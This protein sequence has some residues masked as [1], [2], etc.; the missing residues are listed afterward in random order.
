MLLEQCAALTLRHTAPDA[1]LHAVVQG[2]GSALGDHRAMPTDDGGL[3]L[4]SAADEKLVGISRAAE[5]FRDPRDSGF[6]ARY[7]LN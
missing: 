5:T 6:P 1:E 4:S 7:L 3:S 2:V